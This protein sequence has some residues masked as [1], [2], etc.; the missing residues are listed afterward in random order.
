[1]PSSAD[2][3]SPPPI[4]TTGFATFRLLGEIAVGQILGRLAPEWT[5]LHAVPVGAG[6]SDIDHVLIG[7]AG[8][9][10][11]NTKNHAG[12]TVW[13]ADRAVMIDGHKQ[14][15]LSHSRHEAARAEKRLS[16]AVGEPALVTPVLVIFFVGEPLQAVLNA[17]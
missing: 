12:K 17:L 14:H 1:M 3:A 10:T 16:A 7:P 2:S 13:V 4:R 11:L 6:V 9:F 15:Y 8:V 5:V